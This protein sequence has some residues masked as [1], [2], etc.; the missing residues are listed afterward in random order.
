M[1]YYEEEGQHLMPDYL[2]DK[3][4]SREDPKSFIGFLLSLMKD[5]EDEEDEEEWE[6]NEDSYEY[7]TQPDGEG[8]YKPATQKEQ[9]RELERLEYEEQVRRRGY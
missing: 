5:E 3:I 9:L 8:R 6:D 4:E 2:M 1:G 7:E